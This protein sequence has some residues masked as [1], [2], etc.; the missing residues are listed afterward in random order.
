MNEITEIVNSTSTI[1]KTLY[2]MI[3]KM[4]SPN[5]I[6]IS[7]KKGESKIIDSLSD[8]IATDIKN[9]NPVN[10]TELY[11][12]LNYKKAKK[13]FKN[14]KDIISFALQKINE[15]SKIENIEDDWFSFYFDKV[16]LVSDKSMQQVWS[17]ILSGEINSP[18]KFQRSLLHKISIMNTANANDFCNLVR[19]SFFEYG[20]YELMHPLIYISSNIE[21]YEKSNITIEK[22]LELENLGLISCNFDKEYVFKK[23]KRLVIGN[24]DICIYGDENTEK[25]PAGNVVFTKDGQSLCSIVGQEYKDYRSDILDYTISKL[26]GRRCKV[27]VNGKLM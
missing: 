12:L 27:F 1:G 14:C 8:K 20:N 15:G 19:F 17:D 16:K 3:D 23:K 2:D 7:I 4:F 25:I 6:N 13:E 26:K 21:T 18:G 24:K 11:V 9:G 22:L 5:S 10:E